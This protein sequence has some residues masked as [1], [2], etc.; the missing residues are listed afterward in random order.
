MKMANNYQIIRTKDPNIIEHLLPYIK[1]LINKSHEDYSVDSFVEWFRI[2]I[3][4][5]LV[6]TWIAIKKGNKLI[7]GDTQII[8]YAIATITSDLEK[9]YLNIAH[10]YSEN[11][12]K[13]TKELLDTIE[14]WAKKNGLHV[15]GGV[16]KRNPKAWEK[17]YGYKLVGYNMMK[18]I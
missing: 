12:K 6:K 18:E 16:T 8:G 13:L 4:S 1:K 10:L 7:E 14:D 17:L 11:N 3:G 2:R 9:E 5:S 15:I